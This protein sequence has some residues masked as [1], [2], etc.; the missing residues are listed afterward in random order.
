MIWPQLSEESGAGCPIDP[1]A[2]ENNF[3]ASM[4][5]PLPYASRERNIHV[6]DFFLDDPFSNFVNLSGLTGRSITDN[7]P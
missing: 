7:Y 2:L 3:G 4:L 6:S 1:A 5:F